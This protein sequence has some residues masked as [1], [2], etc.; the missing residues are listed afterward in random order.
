MIK[1][2]RPWRSG[3]EV[4]PRKLPPRPRGCPCRLPPGSCFFHF[5]VK[6]SLLNLILEK[7]IYS[8]N[9]LT[10]HRTRV[11]CKVKISQNF[12]AFSEYMNFIRE[13]P[14]QYD[15]R[16]CWDVFLTYSLS[17]INDYIN[18]E[19]ILSSWHH[20]SIFV[21]LFLTNQKYFSHVYYVPEERKD[22]ENKWKLRP[23]QGAFN[24]LRSEFN[25]CFRHTLSTVHVR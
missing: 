8:E 2:R 18:S 20:D 21:M 15:A 13:L 17:K 12:V 25:H 24:A 6:Q 1:R 3:P 9:W 23:Q 4:A 14:Q 10:L 16:V 7:F 19:T 5:L 11:R 22:Q